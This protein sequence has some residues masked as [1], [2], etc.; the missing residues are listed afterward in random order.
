MLRSNP[1]G[2]TLMLNCR[3]TW[4]GPCR[5]EYPELLGTLPDA[6]ARWSAHRMRIVDHKSFLFLI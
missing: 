3:A 4:C 2:T 1:T 6:R 5:I